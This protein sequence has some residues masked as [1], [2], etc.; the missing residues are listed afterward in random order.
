M[1]KIDRLGWAAGMSFDAYGVRVGVRVNKPAILSRLARL[2]PPGSKLT[3]SPLVDQM[4][5]L[6][7]GERRAHARGFHLLY[8]GVAR[9][10][11]TTSLDELLDAF[12]ADLRLSVATAARRRVFVHA[13]VVGWRGRAIV[14]P[15]R[16]GSGKT[17]L[18]VELVRA[19]ATYYSDEFAVID[20]RGRVH[21]F[22]KPLSIRDGTRIRKQCAEELGGTVGTAPLP[23]GLI[24]FSAYRPGARW[25]PVPLSP[26][27]GLLA[28]IP[29]T[30]PV[31]RWPRASLAALQRVVEGACAFKA[32]RGQ[33]ED[34]AAWLLRHV[35]ET[36]TGAA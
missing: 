20:E 17:T 35:A 10:A 28:L 24:A 11:R 8:A 9:R 19:G 16:S 31:R 14:L 12:E 3:A 33:A 34:A 15:G 32:S 30:V 2:F 13:G 26:G 23:I 5:S 18:V 7:L 21:P 22:A 4:Y 6:W 1:A 36:E 29:H 25:R 27:Q